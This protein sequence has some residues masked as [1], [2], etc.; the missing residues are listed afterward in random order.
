MPE[1]TALARLRSRFEIPEAVTFREGPNGLVR[2]A[3]AGVSGEAHV[4]LHGGHVTHYAPAGHR[5]VLFTSARS[6]FARDKAIRGGVP[7]IF[8]WFGA[9]AGHPQAPQHGFA[10]VAEWD[11]VAA[12]RPDGEAPSLVLGLRP[13]DASRAAW[14]FDFDLRYRIRVGS[15]LDLTL[16]VRNTS[17]EPFAF[18]EAL[19]TYLAVADVTDVAVTGL[20]GATYID[21]VDG[22][23]RKRQGSEPVRITGETDRVYLDTRAACVVDDPRGGR[24][25]VVDKR[26]SGSTVVWNPWRDKAGAMADFGAEEW[27]SMLCIETANAADDAVTLAPGARHEMRASIGVA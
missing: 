1:A 5:P 21:K 7:I 12:E 16:E 20:A 15:A 18:E 22:M 19:H 17:A 26:G 13:S 27:R 2:V 3:V 6:F 24:R 14:P 9:R 25:L 10:R 8:P 4:Y 23:A 11:V